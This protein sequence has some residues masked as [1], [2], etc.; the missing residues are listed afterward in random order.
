MLVGMK[1]CG[2]EGSG[3]RQSGRHK[4]GRGWSWQTEASGVFRAAW[5]GG[6]EGC[7]AHATVAPWHWH[8][9][10]APSLHN[11]CPGSKQRCC[12]AAHG[13]RRYH[14][15]PVCTMFPPPVPCVFCCCQPPELAAVGRATHLRHSTALCWCCQRRP[16]G[17]LLL[18]KLCA[19]AQGSLS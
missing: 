18:E 10:W 17:L 19:L 3:W 1:G 8:Y 12:C 6:L 5:V 2:M 13:K 14:S 9:C 7:H 15:M 4:E 16:V 11:C